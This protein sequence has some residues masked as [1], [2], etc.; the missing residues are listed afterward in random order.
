[1][2]LLSVLM[3][4]GPQTIG[5]LKARTERQHHFDS[6]DEVAAVLGGL[7]LVAD[8]GLAGR[9]VDL[10]PGLDE[11]A[12]DHQPDAPAPAGDEGDPPVEHPHQMGRSPVAERVLP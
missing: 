3:L 8:L 10:G 6:T 4:R 2:A 9:D 12:G 5:E 11:A 1:M 7:D